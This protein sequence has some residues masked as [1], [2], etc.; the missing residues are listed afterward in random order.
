M[1]G[2][3]AEALYAQDRLDEAQQMI[4]EAETTAV[5]SQNQVWVLWRSV[6]AKVLARRGQFAAA[7]QL[8]AEAEE[9]ISSAPWILRAM[10]PV[11]KAE[12]SRLA[13]D[14]DQAAA[15]L[16]AALRIYEDRHAVP[17]AERVKAQLASLSAPPGQGSG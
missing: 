2:L 12:V 1:P 10:V 7:M 15:S 5:S 11:A 17:L 16:N 9:G 6:K 13:G 3:L 8:I 14:P 4:E